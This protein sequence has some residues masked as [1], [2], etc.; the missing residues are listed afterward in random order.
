[1][2]KLAI[3][4]ALA[5]SAA[6]AADPPQ[7]IAVHA[8]ASAP[9]LDGD[10]KDWGRDG[11]SKVRI[12]PAVDKG[13]RARLGLA[14]EDRNHTGTI[15][16]ELKAGVARGRFYLAARWPD[17][18]QDTEYKGW[19]WVG[20]RYAEG[21][22]LEDMF[23][24]RFH[25][26]GDFDRSMLS[27]SSYKVDVWQWSAART[28]P[29]ALAEDTQHLITTRMLDDAAEYEVPGIGTVYIKRTRDAGNP[30]YRMV[31]P[32]KVKEADR[33]PL[34]EMTGNASGSAA[35]VA[36]KGSWKDG[37]WTLEFGRAMD[38]AHPDD[39]AFKAGQK[40]FGQIAVWNHS[41]D[42]H[43]SVSE[44]LLFDFSGIK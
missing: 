36:A 8:L 33:L 37:H 4:A 13:E 12:K 15:T 23:A 3:L 2:F 17:D 20:N 18:T 24:V 31:R 5:A 22:K 26:E 14:G 9:T 1:M 29:A 30:I 39:V 34:F 27:R 16:V 38:S 21:R 32:P 42:E 6:G 19:E 40:L 7:S 44:P 35:D 11:W 41:S 25:M 28:N 10:A 43:K